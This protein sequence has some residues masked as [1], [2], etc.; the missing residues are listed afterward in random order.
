MALDITNGDILVVGVEEYP[1][2][3]VSYWAGHGV[4]NGFTKMATVTASTKRSPAVSGGKIGTPVT[5]IS[6]LTCTPLDPVDPELR[7]RL[8]LDTPHEVLQVYVPDTAGF[9]H[10]ILEE[11]KR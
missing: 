7:Q 11:L 3:A 6:S 8:G 9:F 10:L 2:R 4:T 1:I 5:N